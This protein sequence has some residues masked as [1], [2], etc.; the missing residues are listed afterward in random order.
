MEI[1]NSF[2]KF[3]NSSD[4]SNFIENM[5]RL[6]YWAFGYDLELDPNE[7]KQLKIM[8]E[9]LELMEDSKIKQ[10]MMEKLKNLEKNARIPKVV[11]CYFGGNEPK[12]E[13]M[14]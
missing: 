8:I 11:T 7:I 9:K 10:K 14:S 6:A 12:C 5:R 3:K 13:R 4:Q 2:I 1:M